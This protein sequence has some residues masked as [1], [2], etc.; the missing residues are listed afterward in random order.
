MASSSP[1]GAIDP[2]EFGYGSD[3]TFAIESYVSGSVSQA[4][5]DEVVA[6]VGGHFIAS[7]FFAW[8]WM[9]TI[10]VQRWARCNALRTRSPNW[11]AGFSDG[12]GMIWPMLFDHSFRAAAAAKTS[13]LMPCK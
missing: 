10:P 8:R 11:V 9:D 1:V 3:E 12:R 4:R 13:S 6:R 2:D 5:D 7:G